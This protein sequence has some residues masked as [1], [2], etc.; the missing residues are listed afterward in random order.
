MLVKDLFKLNKDFKGFKILAGKN[1][2]NNKITNVD[3]MEVPDGMYWTKPNDFI[4][5]TGYCIKKG[6][7]SLEYIIRTMIDKKAA[8]LGIKIGRFIDEIPKEILEL[9][10]KYNFP[11]I[12]IPINTSYANI[13]GPILSTLKSSENYDFYIIKE[14]KRELEL[15][16]KKDYNIKSIT[17]LMSRYIGH[18]IYIYW[19]ENLNVKNESNNIQ[20]INAKKIIKKNLAKIYASKD[21][22]SFEDKKYNYTVFK[23]KGLNIILG[24]ICIVLDKE[25]ILT[26]VDVN[27]VREVIPT[28]SIYLLSYSNQVIV[29]YRNIDD[30]YF[31]VL[32]GRYLNNEF[33]LKEE[34]SYL[35]LAINLSRVVW[36]LDFSIKCSEE[37]KD[38]EK[39]MSFIL[40]MQN[41]VYYCQK[42]NRRFIF[43]MEFKIPP[44]DSE[45][46]DGFYGNI[47]LELKKFFKNHSF[48]IGVSKICNN[49]K[50]LNYAYEEAE[51][52]LKIGKKLN[53]DRNVFY[54]ND[55]IIYH[56]LYEIGDHP[57]LLKIYRNTVERLIDYDF[58]NNSELLYTTKVYIDND[59]NINQ[60]SEKLF[61]HRNTLYKRIDRINSILDFDI[62]KSENSLILQISLKLNEI[63]IKK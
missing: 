4:I 63:L 5:T 38:L 27:I 39:R 54:Y 50:Y 9:A 58:K 8:A 42:C 49:L 51:F 60:A 45:E 14:V 6:D 26:K 56:L 20:G 2:L 61:I 24:F 7:T 57:T 32:E 23:I 30:F 28:I 34:A 3:I 22:I 44:K 13:M 55:Y 29:N 10:D 15:L 47:L 48:N 40:G 53:Y 62:N 25:K 19:D 17:N 52:S 35:D 46:I 43:I 11:I 31:S 1:G 33:K 41:N 37:Y 16:L 12:F 18:D 59:F 36:I 21:S